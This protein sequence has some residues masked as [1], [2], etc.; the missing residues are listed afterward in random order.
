MLVS[1]LPVLVL[2][3]HYDCI[4]VGLKLLFYCFSQTTTASSSVRDCFVDGRPAWIVPASGI[5]Y[6]TRAFKLQ[7]RLLHATPA[8]KLLSCHPYVHA[9]TNQDQFTS[10]SAYSAS[11]RIS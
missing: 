6:G 2:R 3:W 7:D 11:R 1:R 4:N 8:L 5:L 10:S 9:V